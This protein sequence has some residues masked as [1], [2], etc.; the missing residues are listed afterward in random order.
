[1]SQ[2][3]KINLED[4]SSDYSD[5]D[6]EPKSE[7]LSEKELFTKYK[8][9]ELGSYTTKNTS[10]RYSNAFNDEEP[11]SAGFRQYALKPVIDACYTKGSKYT[12]RFSN[13][14]SPLSAAKAVELKSPQ[15]SGVNKPRPSALKKPLMS[16][17]KIK[18]RAYK[19]NITV[20]DL[21][22]PS[23]DDG[24]FM[25]TEIDEVV[26]EPAQSHKVDS[27]PSGIVSSPS[28]LKEECAN[29]DEIIKKYEN[30]LKDIN[31]EFKSLLQHNKFLEQKLQKNRDEAPKAELISQLQ[32]QIEDLKMKQKG[33]ENQTAKET[34]HLEQEIVRISHLLNI[35]QNREEKLKEENHSFQLAIQNHET[36]LQKHVEAEKRA[37]QE[38]NHLLDRLSIAE[39]SSKHYEEVTKSYSQLKT[40]YQVS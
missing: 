13:Y 32:R 28:K 15:Y 38:I 23:I 4:R 39:K 14:G 1:M 26:Q 37:Q 8:K 30:A 9:I 29:K 27:N 7:G 33:Y 6:T 20:T 17:E 22:A 10:M 19:R 18:T 35:S 12:R 24:N 3:L 21:K 16:D 2:A 34:E 31:K 36:V 40:T 11:P 25:D 5:K